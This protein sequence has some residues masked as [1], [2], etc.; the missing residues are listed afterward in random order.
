MDNNQESVVDYIKRL[1]KEL[2]ETLTKPQERCEL[3]EIN[4]HVP[5]IVKG[6]HGREIFELLQNADDAYQ[7]YL[8]SNVES[9]EKGTKVLIEYTDNTLRISNKGA[10]FQKKNI[11]TIIYGYET[12]K[13]QNNNYIG[14]KGTGFRSVL[15]WASKIRLFS[16][17]WNLE[18]SKENASELFN[19]IKDFPQIKKQLEDIKNLEVP[20]LYA[21]K[22]IDSP[23]EKQYDTIIVIDVIPEKLNDG[24]GVMEQI[25][26][27]DFS[28][29]LFLPNI[30][31]IEINTDEC[32]TY[33]KK[34]LNHEKNI[35]ELSHSVYE[36][37]DLKI[38]KQEKYYYRDKIKK[39]LIR[40][41]DIEK[42]I[43]LGIGIPYF[44]PDEKIE[45]ITNIKLY[46]FFPL[47]NSDS[48][49]NLLLHA[50]YDLSTNR[51]NLN[52][53]E[54][55]G[56]ILKKQLKFIIELVD[57]FS[58]KEYGDLS[59]RIATPDGIKGEP[60][61]FNGQ[62]SEYKYEEYYLELL[63]NC[64][65]LPTINSEYISINDNPKL[66]T[67]K[68][69]STFIGKEFNN[70][71]Q[72]MSDH[73]Y[74]ALIKKLAMHNK[75]E[76]NF[77]ASEL[78]SK[79]NNL[80]AY[81][82][83]EQ[84]IETF[85]WWEKEEAYK[86]IQVLP[87]L[88]KYYNNDD[89]WVTVEADIYFVTGRELKKPKWSKIKQL[90]SQDEKLLIKY[91]KQ[92]PDFQ[93]KYDEEKLNVKYPIEERIISSLSG[94]I[95]T[96][97]P[98]INFHYLDANTVISPINSSIE[99][100]E[101][102]KEFLLWLWDNYAFKDNEFSN[103]DVPTRDGKQ[104]LVLRLP[105]ALNEVSQSNELFF[106]NSYGNTTGE[107]ICK[108]IKL[109]PF[110]VFDSLG[111]EISLKEDFIA[112]SKKLGVVSYP[113]ISRIQL[114][115]QKFHSEC[116]KMVRNHLSENGD[117]R[118]FSINKLEFDTIKEVEVILGQTQTSEIV[119]W[120]AR[121]SNLKQ[122]IFNR[123][124]N[125]G[126]ITFRI[127]QKQSYDLLYTNVDSY[128]S[129]I[130]S[131]AKWI[132]VNKN[133]FSPSECMFPY[134]YSH[135]DI[136]ISSVTTVLSNEFL[137]DISKNTNLPID[138]VKEIFKLCGVKN[139]VT[140]LP[141]PAFYSILLI[142]PKNNASGNI[143]QKIYREVEESDF[144]R[145]FENCTE[146]EKYFSEGEVFTKNKTGKRSYHIAKESYFSNKTELNISNKQIMCT[147]LRSGN[148]ENFKNV[149]NVKKFTEEYTLNPGSEVLAPINEEFQMHFTL[150]IK[151]AKAWS[152]RNDNIKQYIH[153]LK[154]II[155][156][157]IQIQ[158]SN[159]SEPVKE[160]YTLLQ[161][162]N[163]IWY[164]IYKL[165]D[166][167]LREISQYIEEIFYKM[168]NLTNSPIPRQLGDLF[169]APD[170]DHMKFLVKREFGEDLS[171]NTILKSFCKALNLSED[172]T[173]VQGIDF[174]D[175]NSIDSLS[176]IVNIL[177]NLKLD[178]NDLYSAGFEYKIDFS[179]YWQDRTRAFIE[180]NEQKY[181]TLLYSKFLNTT[182]S[183]QETFLDKY[184][185]F[186]HFQMNESDIPNSILFSIDEYIPK[187]FPDIIHQEKEKYDINIEDIYKQNHETIVNE[188]E[189]DLKKEF[190]DYIDS[191]R[192][193]KSL[194][195]FLKESNTIM[196]VILKDFS[197]HTKKINEKHAK[198]FLLSDI[199][200]DDIKLTKPKINPN[201]ISD[202]P[203]NG[204]SPSQG[205]TQG[206][207]ERS[208]K[209]KNY[210]GK[211]AEEK[212]YTKLRFD[213]RYS[214]LK[215]TSEKSKI[216][217]DREPSNKY[218]LK[219]KK[220]GRDYFIE[221]KSATSEFFMSSEEYK[222]AKANQK[223]Y[224]IF[225]V[226]IPN[227]EIC[228]PYSLSDFE[229]CKRPSE[230]RFVFAKE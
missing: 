71:L 201:A 18:F 170:E 122:H 20:I 154:M 17:D 84:R 215:W 150:F 171:Q 115:D 164:L 204:R 112:F 95:N 29:L 226:D 119:S 32:I 77:T 212:V 135:S 36:N 101:Q 83:D 11:R 111:I 31:E 56:K 78:A 120:I 172:D 131:N 109:K 108:I 93:Q 87:N 90:S 174:E 13:G 58:K 110:I 123:H 195:Y 52:P 65:F 169:M 221:V 197:E 94:K 85:F 205:A 104:P 208:E 107:K 181:R 50:T 105:N 39:N 148:Y 73:D 186:Y 121:D 30:T 25:K 38:K 91:A 89:D 216:T 173:R 40:V 41:D 59:V 209:G 198:D 138:K 230:Y 196:E 63:S 79:I 191:R 141:S 125:Y 14:N 184:Y 190:I 8:L 21:P 4:S 102:S 62:L 48:P 136:D 140:D 175:L 165:K 182:I 147:T 222:F 146:K 143:S 34:L 158:M 98:H 46:C 229:P 225:L 22:C 134:S 227:N 142:L 54:I 117:E 27:L 133:R 177:N 53:G 180:G 57:E 66:I 224:E 9:R 7:K 70:L 207:L 2:V 162:K 213:T 139:K 149:F 37:D 159:E 106:D 64:K 75:K 72:W 69:P 26:E 24:F 211:V 223:Y 103:W 210:T 92:S 129:Y 137:S 45:E 74:D 166:L 206:Q 35:Y 23:K 86:N 60:F 113:Q 199:D 3:I 100:Y 228:G 218:D 217:E 99:N 157:S 187:K 145:K 16:G 128:I 80:S 132:T 47:K 185:A 10:T 51:N 156:S 19:E 55:N 127:G 114:T 144:N 167:N 214:E 189:N 15:N 219:F 33:K 168:V 81:W 155:I 124:G 82:T 152:E 61:K 67:S 161:G 179:P 88:L 116:L 1:R 28:V 12:E 151:Y 178:I 6:Y 183:E 194:V 126:E 118:N 153:K 96:L 163:Q 202:S 220:N 193:K 5:D 188:V 203:I 43:K 76:L 130:F 97:I 160:D 200:K 176:A 192:N 49:F 44:E 42:G 68:H